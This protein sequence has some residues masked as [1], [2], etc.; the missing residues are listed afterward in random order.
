VGV[1]V[2]QPTLHRTKFPRQLG[3]RQSLRPEFQV[4][5]ID[6]K[7]VRMAAGAMSLTKALPG[8]RELLLLLPMLQKMP[9]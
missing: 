1:E 7:L 9:R 8:T 6:P 5:R 2:N 3:E 4:I